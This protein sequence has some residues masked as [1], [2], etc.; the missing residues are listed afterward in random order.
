MLQNV[1][2]DFL[3]CHI[4]QVHPA[5]GVIKPG[6][7][8]GISVRHDEFLTQEAFVDGVRN[9]W[10]CEDTRD[11]EAVLLINVT[12]TYSTE[13]RTHRLHVR[14]CYSPASLSG[15][16]KGNTSKRLQSSHRPRADF[17]KNA[18]NGH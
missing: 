3:I 4:A 18:T 8:V 13:R 7:I 10:L 9:N 6:Q 1:G 14:R 5:V 15:E 11:K 16:P 2:S 12:G 17:D